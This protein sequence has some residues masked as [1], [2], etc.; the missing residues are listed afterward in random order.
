MNPGVTFMRFFV[1]VFVFDY[2]V[3]FDLVWCTSEVIFL[4]V[5][6]FLVFVRIYYMYILTGLWS[7]HRF[8]QS[9]FVFVF[10]LVTCIS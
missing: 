10:F 5:L 1:L 6:V 8:G 7:L 3:V 4:S 9:S 2:C